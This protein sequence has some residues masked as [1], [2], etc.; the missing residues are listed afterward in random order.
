[1]GSSLR[2]GLQV[3]NVTNDEINGPWK[4]SIDY[5]K[6]RGRGPNA[7]EFFLGADG[8]LE[9]TLDY[10]GRK[11]A[12]SLLFQSKTEWARDTALLTQA[13]RL[14]TWREAAIFINYTPSAFYA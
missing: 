2:S 11:D 4:W 6:F 8:I 12:K 5:K 7:T 3:I 14:S 10:G 1:L 13:A 9:L